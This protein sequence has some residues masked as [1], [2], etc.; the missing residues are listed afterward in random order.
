MSCPCTQVG[1]CD[2]NMDHCSTILG[3][4]ILVDVPV[5]VTPMV[6]L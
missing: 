5:I 1:S 4:I 2:V 3:N 6:L